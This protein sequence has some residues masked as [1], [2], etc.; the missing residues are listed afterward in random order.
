MTDKTATERLRALLNERKQAH[1]VWPSGLVVWHEE[2]SWVYEYSPPKA[3]GD[4]WGGTKK[5]LRAEAV[6]RL[7]NSRYH[8]MADYVMAMLGWGHE[9][10]Y[11]DCRDALIDLLTDEP[12]TFQA[13]KV[14]GSDDQPEGDGTSN[15][16]G[17]GTR[18]IDNGTCPDGDAV[19]IMCKV[20]HGDEVTGKAMRK[21]VGG[22]DLADAL[23]ILADM[24]ERDYVRR[25]EYDEMEYSL[26][27][28]GAN[29][30]KIERDMRKK[31]EAE[32]DE[33]KAKAEALEA[34]RQNWA[35]GYYLDKL[36]KAE[37]ERDKLQGALDIA[38]Q[39]ESRLEAERDSYRE[40]MLAQAGRVAELI[41]ER[42]EQGMYE[43]G[44][45]DGFDRGEEAILQQVDEI[46]AGV[47]ASNEKVRLLRDM[48]EEHRKEA[49]A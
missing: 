37:A 14:Q 43:E 27:E 18:P 3:E 36:T 24:V 28:V 5:Q 34:D 7:R 40:N 35:D 4:Y 32:R 9:P 17:N 15:G 30:V 45:A 39:N 23:L 25:E 44:Y 6:E 38:V 16:T 21:E 41:A 46:T 8:T 20:A 48:V 1:R 49:G 33:W 13:E 47:E 19:A 26:M 42:D 29:A 2:G 22:T 31:A 12:C 10:H 11:D